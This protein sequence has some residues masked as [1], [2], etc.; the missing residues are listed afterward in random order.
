MFRGLTKV[1][2]QVLTQRKI[3]SAVS[4][5]FDP[6]GLI[7]PFTIRGRLIL[8]DLWCIKGQNWDAPVPDE[9]REAFIEWDSEKVE[10]SSISIDGCIFRG[11]SVTN[12]QLHV[13]VDAS[14]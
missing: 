7:S 13:F 9:I 3:L 2:T 14:Q 10:V 11:S 4:G 5:I 8:K 12:A 1:S 6:M